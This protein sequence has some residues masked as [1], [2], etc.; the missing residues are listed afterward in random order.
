[1]TTKKILQKDIPPLNHLST[2]KFEKLSNAF[3]ISCIIYIFTSDNKNSL[4]KPLGL[5]YSLK[6]YWIENIYNGMRYDEIDYTIN[7]NKI[8]EVDADKYLYKV[9]LFQ[10]AYTNLNFKSLNKILKLEK[11]EDFLEFYKIYKYENPDANNEYEGWEQINWK[12]VYMDYGGIELSDIFLE[13]VY[14]SRKWWWG[15]DIPSGC[16]WNKD[17]IKTFELIL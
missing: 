9:E 2:H 4:L 12:K 1:M 10:D 6:W 14:A 3:F 5:W 15:W 8:Y 7:D 11:Y 16:V 13:K 17:L